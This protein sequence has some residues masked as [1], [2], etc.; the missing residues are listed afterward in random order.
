M[1][2]LLLNTTLDGSAERWAL[3]SEDGA[4]QSSG[5]G[6]LSLAAAEVQRNRVVWLPRGE[7]VLLLQTS[8]P[9]QSR[10]EL[11][12]AV[13][14]AVEDD[15]ATS[16]DSNAICFQKTKQGVA[17][18]IAEAEKLELGYQRLVKAGIRP[19]IIAP[20]VLS[21]PWY[22]GD[23]TL[24]LEQDRALLRNDEFAGVVCDRENL[25][26]VL[27]QQLAGMEDDLRPKVLHVWGDADG[28]DDLGIRL[29]RARGNALDCLAVGVNKLPSLNL[30]SAL[31]SSGKLDGDDTRR[32]QVAAVLAAI[33]LAIGLFAQS[34]ELARLEQYNQTLSQR[35]E[36]LYRETFPA[37]KR[38]VKPRFQMEQQL[39][40][41]QRG[42]TGD[43]GFL[44]QLAASLPALQGAKG[45]MLHSLS[46]QADN[47]TLRFQVPDL[48][49][50]DRLKQ[51]LE[52][53]PGLAAKIQS[54]E[55]LPKA[56]RAVIR[57]NGAVS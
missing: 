24:L 3:V 54:V 33:A 5:E 41:L 15:L 57:I 8:V 11:Q 2:T 32:F 30:I 49:S 10:K 52:E 25:R 44:A 28:L 45:V 50:L 17:V 53:I 12:Q 43:G 6:E 14:Y 35:I 55:K 22:E 56:V 19:R 46:Y 29:Q 9:A 4:V 26:W 51:Q 1:D 7:D 37:A 13:P 40:E 23:W 47:L 39:K 34:W 48:Q 42:R 27:E 38:V 36:S 18:A 20:D 16:V 21:L 31:G